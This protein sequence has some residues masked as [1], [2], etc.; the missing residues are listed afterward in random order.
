VELVTFRLR[1]MV[2]E[3]ESAASERDELAL[4][5][6]VAPALLARLSA[7]GA[8]L[9]R[10]QVR[11]RPARQGLRWASSDRPSG[12]PGRAWFRVRFEDLTT[13]L[14]PQGLVAARAETRELELE[15]DTATSP[16]RLWQVLE[17]DRP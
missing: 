13:H 4:A 1:Q 3:L 17:V 12:G 6:V 9:A 14:G 7:H 5:R 2:D 16:W 8:E 11:W 10:E 15:V